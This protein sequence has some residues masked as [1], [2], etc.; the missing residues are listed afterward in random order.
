VGHN[1]PTSDVEPLVLFIGSSEH[2]IDAKLRLAVPAKYRNQWVAERDGGA[3]ICVPW[4]TGHLRL[5]TEADFAKLADSAPSSLTPDQ[6]TA[7]LE[8]DFFSLAERLE[9]DSAGRIN[10]PRHHVELTGLKSEVAVVGARNRLEIH[11]LATWK[12]T[13]KK[14]FESLP[15]LVNRLQQKPE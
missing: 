4:S 5:Y 1:P 13:Q 14:R 9:M 11:D 12:S 3:W 2:T 6:A 8:A 15:D 7:N 10:L